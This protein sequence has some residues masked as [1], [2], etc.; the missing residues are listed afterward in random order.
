ML[1]F[2]TTSSG[3][4][5]WSE[6]THSKQTRRAA[7]CFKRRQRTSSAP[8]PEQPLLPHAQ[9]SCDTVQGETEVEKSLLSFVNHTVA[10]TLAKVALRRNGFTL[11]HISGGP[12]VGWRKQQ[13][14]QLLHNNQGRAARW[15]KYLHRQIRT[16]TKAPVNADVDKA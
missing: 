5:I 14:C 15:K 12:F 11:T 1:S 6:F 2:Y 7:E 16:R 3:E 8:A 9:R 4:T 13:K 10:L